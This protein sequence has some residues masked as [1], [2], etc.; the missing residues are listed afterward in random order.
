[1]AFR[2]DTHNNPTAFTTDIAKTA[3]L[4]E[5]KDYEVGSPFQA[6]GRTYFTA[7]ILGDAIKT[8]IT[9]IDRISFYTS[10]GHIRWIYIGIPRFIWN[11]LNTFEKTEVIGFMYQHEGGTEMKH[12]FPSDNPSAINVRLGDTMEMKDKLG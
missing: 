10:V 2:T 6:D 7:K 11:N 5:G 4:I 3:N 8:T 1:M 12:L 9:V